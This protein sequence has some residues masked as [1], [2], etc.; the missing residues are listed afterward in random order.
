VTTDPSPAPRSLLIPSSAGS[1]AALLFMPARPPAGGLLVCHGAGSCKENHA[2]MA[3]QA[4]AAGLAALVFDFRGHG[5]SDGVMDAGGVDDVIAAADALRREARV[6]WL[7]ARGSSLGAF[8]LLSAARQQPHLFRAVAALCPAD[9]TS[10]L[11][12][13][14]RFVALDAAGGPDAD[15]AGRFD[16]RGLRAFWGTTDLVETARGLRHVLL[17]HARDDEDVPFAVSERLAAELAE[18]TR[19]I[20]LETGGHKGPQRSPEV[21]RATIDWALDCATRRPEQPA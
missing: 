8:W 6:P 5:A 13:L 4:A 10:L 3:E 2:V 17:A 9:E 18:P 16:V 19:F 20:V 15:F 21:A 14:D 11:A 12:G 7:A 1:L